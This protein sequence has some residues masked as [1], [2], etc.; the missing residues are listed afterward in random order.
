[1]L[2]GHVV[3]EFHDDHGLA[4]AGAAEEADL[5]A[6]QEGLDQVD[7][8]YSG[9]EHLCCGRLFIERGGKT[10]NGHSLFKG[11]RAEVIHG[12]ADY[13]H[14]SAQRSAAYGGG[15]GATLIDGF[16]ASHHAVGGFHGDAADAAFA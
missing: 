10:V 11:N 3:D 15:D 4:Y 1:M 2:L 14:H 9:L 5:S 16:H 6:F 12:F 7:N 8:F 13:I